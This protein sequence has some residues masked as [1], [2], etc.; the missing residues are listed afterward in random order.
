MK[1]AYFFCKNSARDPV[2]MSVYRACRQIAPFED[3]TTF[4]DGSAVSRWNTIHGDCILLV[5]TEE[6]ITD[7]Y[8]R[9]VDVL[10]TLFANSTFAGVVNWH[11]GKNAPERIFTVHSNADVPS[12]NFGL[13]DPSCMRALLLSLE[14]ARLQF[15]LA[16]WRTV[17][18]ASHWSGSIAG[19]RP[20]LLT[21]LRIPLFDIEIGSTATSWHNAQAVTTLASGLLRIRQKELAV[22]TSLLCLGGVHLESAFRDAVIDCPSRGY[23][24]SHI[25][26]N[27]WVSSDVYCGSEG[28]SK[29]RSCIESIRGGIQAIVYHDSLKGIYKQTVRAAANELGV[30]IMNHRKLRDGQL[31][32]A[33]PP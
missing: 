13:T 33:F 3:T 11:E 18:E 20:E 7:R 22:F 5:L 26:P 14:A 29:L 8:D 23:A 2:A 24:V 6:I 21:R 4:L 1:I 12:G 9:Y 15:G 19:S 31:S 10:N 32:L 17:V 16:D 30:D 25:L 27:R 28:I